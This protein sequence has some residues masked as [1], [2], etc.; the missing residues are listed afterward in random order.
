MRKPIELSTQYN[1]IAAIYRRRIFLYNN[2][3]KHPKLVFIFKQKDLPNTGG[4]MF[5]INP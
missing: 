1:D 4:L 2:K 5:V 3:Y